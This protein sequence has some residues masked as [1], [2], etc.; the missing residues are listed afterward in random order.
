VKKINERL[1]A[2]KVPVIF[3][4]YDEDV[5]LREGTEL[6]TAEKQAF[7]DIFLKHKD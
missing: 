6:N 2:N 4:S 1:I 7:Y 3:Q 5:V